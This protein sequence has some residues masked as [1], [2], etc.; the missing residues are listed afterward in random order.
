[1]FATLLGFSGLMFVGLLLAVNGVEIPLG[2][3]EVELGLAQVAFGV[4]AFAWLLLSIRCN[5]C[6]RSV[7]WAFMSRGDHAT[8]WHRMVRAK[9]CPW[10][11]NEP[12]PSA[13]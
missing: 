7:P 3:S 12:K 2:A 1:M 8:W 9:R 6:K 5:A 11:E 13:V 4:L 10:C